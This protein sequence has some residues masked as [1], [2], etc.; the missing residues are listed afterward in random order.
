MGVQ[1]KPAVTS[2]LNFS[3]KILIFL[4]IKHFN[5]LSEQ[6][7]KGKCSIAN[8]LLQLLEQTKVHLLFTILVHFY[9]KWELL[10]LVQCL[11]IVTF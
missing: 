9:T 5:T 1:E 6:L 10:L 7:F 2:Q 4:E 8:F 3:L 11:R